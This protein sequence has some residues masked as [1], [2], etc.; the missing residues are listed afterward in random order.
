MCECHDSKMT[1]E[2]I[3]IGKEY[4]H[5]AKTRSSNIWK[6]CKQARESS[7]RKHTRRVEDSHA[8]KHL[9]LHKTCFRVDGDCGMPNKESRIGCKVGAK[10]M[11][12]CCFVMQEV[13]Q[14]V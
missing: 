5:D 11:E 7:T 13:G 1:A 10:K 8:S 9:S 4:N 3:R 12:I 14:V 6:I 2:H